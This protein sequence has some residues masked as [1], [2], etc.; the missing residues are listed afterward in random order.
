VVEALAVR[1]AQCSSVTVY[2]LREAGVRG[3][4]CGVERRFMV[5]LPGKHL[6]PLTLDVTSAVSAMVSSVD[7]VHL[8]GLENAFVLP[9]LRWR[10][11]TVVTSHGT[12]YKLGKWS[13]P[14][15]VAMRASEAMAM[16]LASAVTA[17]AQPQAAW[18]ERRYGRPVYWIP[19]GIGVYAVPASQM[20]GGP[21]AQERLAAV[22][23]PY[24]GSDRFWL[25]A[26]SRID[27]GKGCHT[28][29]EAY[30]QLASPPPLVVV[31]DL[32]HA[33]GYEA[34]LR[35]LAQGKSVHFVPRLTEQWELELVLR[36]TELFVFPS[37]VEAMSMMLLEALSVGVVGVA[38]DIP[39]HSSVLP[40]DYPLFKAGD[41]SDLR[42]ALEEVLAWDSARRETAAAAGREWVRNR[43]DWDVIVDCYEALYREAL[44]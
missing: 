36:S 1:Q 3:Q 20:E 31:G 4:Y 6:R 19:N 35:E 33:P 28:L 42:R 15:K 12:A 24:A 29:L 40:P 16:R 26:A 34:L 38:S 7:V 9:L 43:Y 25:F 13:A 32:W 17:V 10:V 8:H 30:G 44:L 21:T 2:G 23:G 18:L 41:A 5:S 27:P 39:E 37:T 11:P 22:L 14:A